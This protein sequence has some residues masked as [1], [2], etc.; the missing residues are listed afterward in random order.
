MRKSDRSCRRE[1][2]DDRDDVAVLLID[3]MRA[4]YY[5][6]RGYSKAYIALFLTIILY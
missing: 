3:I 6:E 2:D 1:S 5:N 4:A